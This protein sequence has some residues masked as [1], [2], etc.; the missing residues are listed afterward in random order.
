M[1]IFRGDEDE[2]FFVSVF[3]NNEYQNWAATISD[4]IIY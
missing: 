2:K 1:P 3:L 4:M